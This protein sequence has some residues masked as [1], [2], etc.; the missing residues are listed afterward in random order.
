MRLFLAIEP[1]PEL[2]QRLA[3]MAE[4]LRGEPATTAA[5][6]WAL[7]V[8]LFELLADRTPFDLRGRTVAEIERIVCRDETPRAS[9]SAPR[10]RT[11]ALRG[12]LDL[13]G[14]TELQEL[15]TG[16]LITFS[17]EAGAILAHADE[18]ARRR[19]VDYAQAVGLAFQIAD[20]LLDA[21]ASPDDLGKPTGQDAA[22]GKA[23]FVGQLGIGGARERAKELVGQAERQLA[24]F[25][26]KADLLSAT[27]RFVVDRRS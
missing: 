17:C 4:Q 15:K 16:A 26:E 1:P 12:D 8:L 3:A 20:D 13:M 22:L 6:V 25:G 23:T 9:E 11:R 21:E 19:I 7:G 5:D 14:I 24:F 27:A 2:R 10:E 18:A